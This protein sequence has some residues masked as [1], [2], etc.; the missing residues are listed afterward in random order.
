MNRR[1]FLAALA[2]GVPAALI[3]PELLLPQRTFFL[4]P[5]MG[6]EIV[7]DL[8]YVDG[9]YHRYTGYEALNIPA[10][11]IQTTLRNHQDAILA[12]IVKQNALFQRLRQ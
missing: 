7:P 3:L 5:T 9:V 4:P 8:A 1:G 6:W 2:A 10:E 11:I 12:N